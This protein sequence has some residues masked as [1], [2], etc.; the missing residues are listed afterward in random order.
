MAWTVAE[1]AGFTL[2]GTAAAGRDVYRP[3]APQGYGTPAREKGAGGAAHRLYVGCAAARRERRK[4][5]RWPSPAPVFA[6]T[7]KSSIPGRTDWILRRA[8]AASNS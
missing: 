3:E 8:A 4:S 1:P 5:S 7:S 2:K 6:D